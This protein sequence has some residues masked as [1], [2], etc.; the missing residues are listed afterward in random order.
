MDSDMLHIPARTETPSRPLL[1]REGGIH[2]NLNLD[3]AY[4]PRVSLNSATISFHDF[5]SAALSYFMPLSMCLAASGT[6]KLCTAPGKFSNLYRAVA[7]SRASRNAAIAFSEMNVSSAPLAI[8]SLGL[9]AF[10]S[11]CV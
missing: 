1:D 4:L 11:S 5:S 2:D 10:A 8:Y 7:L 3:V 9:I 6:V